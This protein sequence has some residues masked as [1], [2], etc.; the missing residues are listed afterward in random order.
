[1]GLVEWEWMQ[2]LSTIDEHDI[3]YEDFIVAARRLAKVLREKEKCDV[4]I[5][6]THMR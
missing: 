3:Q 4:V 1:M 2:T 5:A 6:L